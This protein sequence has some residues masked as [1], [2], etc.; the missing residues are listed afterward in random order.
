MKKAGK[1]TIQTSIPDIPIG[2]YFLTVI[3]GGKAHT[4]KL[5]IK[6]K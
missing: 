6:N 4:N 2:T 1:H 3:S 5:I